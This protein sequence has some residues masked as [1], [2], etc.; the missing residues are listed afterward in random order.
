MKPK[1]NAL[2]TE[3]DETLKWQVI[4]EP[5]GIEGTSEIMMPLSSGTVLERLTVGDSE[6]VFAYQIIEGGKLNGRFNRCA[7]DLALLFCIAN[8]PSIATVWSLAIDGN[9][10]STIS[11]WH[12]QPSMASSIRTGTEST[13]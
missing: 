1:G 8:D 11:A 2:T 6:L 3:R 4:P 9:A 12:C 7:D 13:Q 10:C 5:S